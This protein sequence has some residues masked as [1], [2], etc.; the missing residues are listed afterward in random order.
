MNTTSLVAEGSPL[1]PSKTQRLVRQAARALGRHRLAHAYGHCSAR[2]DEQHFLVC[3]AKPLG[4]IEPA[5]NGTIVSLTGDLPEGVLGE[6]RIHREIYRRRPDIGGIVRSMPAA[7]MSL[8]ALGRTPRAL[9]GMGAYFAPAA[10]LWN[11]PQLIRN[12]AA[13]EQL[14]ELMAN[15]PAIV[16]R[17][18]GV[19]T[20][21]TSIE[22]AVAL[23]W[24]LEDAARIEL[25]CLSQ[26]DQVREMTL[27]EARQRATRSG[28]I[29]ERMW[30]YL[31]YGDPE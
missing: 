30:D 9:H 13:A 21:A 4:T 22:E 6:V 14:A 16:M 23:T 25:D 11:D 7:A 20:A 31:T 15:A 5:D 2:L 19:V 29:F 12:D 10:P 27:E 8:S 17:G 1:A 3:A 18:N 28:R 26:S 24:Y